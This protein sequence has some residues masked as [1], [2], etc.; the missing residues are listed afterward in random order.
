MPMFLT[1][2]DRGVYSGLKS[3]PA[4][5]FPSCLRCAAMSRQPFL[6]HPA[7]RRA[8]RKTPHPAPMW[9]MGSETRMQRPDHIAK[10]GECLTL[11]P[12]VDT[13]LALLLASLL[14]A[15]AAPT[16]AVYSVLRRATGKAEA[17]RAAAAVSLDE[18]G[19]QLVAAILAVTQSIEGQ[20]ND[21]AHGHWGASDLIPEGILWLDGTYTID[22]HVKHRQRVV[23]ERQIFD[24]DI[25]FR[26]YYY[27]LR[28]FDEII[29]KYKRDM[30]LYLYDARLR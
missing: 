13:Q 27:T 17:I 21:L 20:R 28:D 8:M 22:F 1:A 24:S 6:N 30:P 25:Q 19:Q 14:K 15:D 23:I 12:D 26:L 18:P 7:I 16:V 2:L 29:E 10:I 11:W 4:S 5:G 3:H 9:G